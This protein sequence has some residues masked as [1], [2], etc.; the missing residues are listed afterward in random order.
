MEKK[1]ADEIGC[2]VAGQ[3]FSNV[4]LIFSS[5]CVF[6]KKKKKVDEIGCRVAGQPPRPKNHL[7]LEQRT[8]R[9]RL[10]HKIPHADYISLTFLRCAF[11]NGLTLTHSRTNVR[12]YLYK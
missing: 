10:R 9:C 6:V 12:I 8:A 1:K 7:T 11:S 4:C 2:R 5:E 3:M